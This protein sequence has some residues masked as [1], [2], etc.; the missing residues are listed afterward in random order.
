MWF[1]LM[2][3]FLID[4]QPGFSYIQLTLKRVLIKGRPLKVLRRCRKK[5]KEVDGADAD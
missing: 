1:F 3:F 2:W 4:I 5:R